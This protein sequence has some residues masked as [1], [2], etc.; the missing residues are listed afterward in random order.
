[1]VRRITKT[2]NILGDN[3]LD[4]GVIFRADTR[5]M[6]KSEKLNPEANLTFVGTFKQLHQKMSRQ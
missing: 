1:M 6:R 4:V 3:Y 5:R 2:N